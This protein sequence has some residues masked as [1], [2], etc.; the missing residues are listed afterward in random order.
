MA[1]FGLLTLVAAI[2]STI[3]LVGITSS[4]VVAG[5][6]CARAKFET[7][8]VAEACKAGGQDKAKSEMKAF[9]K[10][11]KK[12]NADASCQSCHKKVGGDYPLKPDAL[13]QFKKYGGE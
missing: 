5:K 1:K 12:Q 3:A 10:K 13:E 2:F 7:K 6:P 8:M 9:L 11:V 4:D